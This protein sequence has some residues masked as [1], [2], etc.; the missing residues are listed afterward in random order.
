ML[1][2]AQKGY[3][4]RNA[5]RNQ[6]MIEWIAMMDSQTAELD[7]MLGSDIQ[8]FEGLAIHRFD[9]V[10]DVGVQLSYSGF[11]HN[12]PKRDR[13]DQNVIGRILYQAPRY[14]P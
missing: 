3:F 7:Q 8:F 4:L 2:F 9:D 10:T 12:L 6:E 5:L 1:V 14:L 11:H 13:A